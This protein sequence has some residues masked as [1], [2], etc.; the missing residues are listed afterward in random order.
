MSIQKLIFTF[1]IMSL[2]AFQAHGQMG[3]G[4]YSNKDNKTYLVTEFGMGAGFILESRERSTSFPLGTL[5][6]EWLYNTYTNFGIMFMLNPKWSMG[7]IGSGGVNIGERTSGSWVSLRA[8]FGR[9][10]KNI[11]TSVSPGLRTTAFGKI[12]GYVIETTVSWKDHI[13]IYTR[14]EKKIIPSSNFNNSDRIYTLGLFTKGKKG[15][16]SSIGS[17]IGASI[18]ASILIAN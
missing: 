10:Y 15:M 4:H 17:L 16:W 8:R 1:S 11:E 13:G 18:F 9:H 12:N 7:V 14:F 5:N 6:G 3:L 2:I